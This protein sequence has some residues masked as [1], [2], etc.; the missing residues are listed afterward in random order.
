[1]IRIL[2]ASIGGILFIAAG[3]AAAGDFASN[4]QVDYF[5]RGTHQFYVWC[6]H[7]NDYVTSAEGASAEEAQLSL[8]QSIKAAGKSNCWPVWQ[9][10]VAAR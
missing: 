8:Y 2:A 5:A 9:G 10:R 7:G 6:A 1:L 4:R 3:V